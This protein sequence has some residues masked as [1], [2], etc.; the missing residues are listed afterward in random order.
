MHRVLATLLVAAVFVGCDNSQADQRTA[1]NAS[2]SKHKSARVY[3]AVAA[4]AAAD[5]AEAE[6]TEDADAARFEIADAARAAG[7]AADACDAATTAAAAAADAAGTDR[8]NAAFRAADDTAQRAWRE[9]QDAFG[10]PP[11]D[12][13]LTP[14]WAQALE[15]ARLAWEAAERA[16][17]S[18]D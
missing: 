17:A 14:D 6:A 15:A 4:Y 18:H 9:A 3:I 13:S 5:A 2:C 7:R 12:P 10:K 16:K 1:Y 11:G 8:F